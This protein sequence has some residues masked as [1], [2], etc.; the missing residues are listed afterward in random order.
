MTATLHVYTKNALLY[1]AQYGIG[2]GWSAQYDQS[3][4][5]IG[6][7]N[8]RERLH[9][10]FCST[11]SSLFDA[12][13]DGSLTELVSAGVTIVE[14]R[15]FFNTFTYY[16]PGQNNPF[17]FVTSPT[18]SFNNNVSFKRGLGPADFKVICASPAR[19]VLVCMDTAADTAP[20]S[21]T[22]IYPLFMIDFGQTVLPSSF[23]SGF[24]KLNWGPSS[25]PPS[26]LEMSL[27]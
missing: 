6:E 24:F 7:V 12:A 5:W 23:G 13:F 11:G 27:A 1:T 14:G 16:V 2:A 22:A 17:N 20:I 9:A 3:L 10:V 8:S 4:G 18:Y 21:Y 19:S 25:Q 26:V 15:I